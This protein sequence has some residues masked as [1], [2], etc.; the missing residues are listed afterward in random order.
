MLYFCHLQNLL[1]QR[2]NQDHLK[3]FHHI[4]DH[5]AGQSKE[6]NSRV[7]CIQVDLTE[8]ILSILPLI[9]NLLLG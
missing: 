6:G 4:L 8:K 5:T 1:I 2:N 9:V 7:L 3:W